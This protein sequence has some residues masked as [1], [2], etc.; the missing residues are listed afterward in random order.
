MPPVAFSTEPAGKSSQTTIPLKKKLFKE[1]ENPR[2]EKLNPPAE[3]D[4]KEKLNRDVI[5][6]K[7]TV[8][9]CEISRTPNADLQKD[10]HHTCE[11]FSVNPS[12]SLQDRVALAVEEY[13]RL[14]KETSHR[15]SYRSECV[16]SEQYE[17]VEVSRSDTEVKSASSNVCPLIQQVS[18]TTILLLVIC[19]EI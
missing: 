17:Y 6:W 9:E 11:G 2:V 16:D 13:R 5:F 19:R 15:S 12:G 7:E 10:S 14:I 3:S 18:T 1:S 8:N 4:I